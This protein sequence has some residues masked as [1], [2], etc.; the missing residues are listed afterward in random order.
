ML[1]HWE[2]MGG[3]GK[4][5]MMPGGHKGGWHLVVLLAHIDDV[6]SLASSSQGQHLERHLS[7]R[8]ELIAV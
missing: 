4:E 8:R 7:E 3:N 6:G 2:R 5:S 1:F